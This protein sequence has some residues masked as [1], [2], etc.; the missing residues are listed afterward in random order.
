M[1]SLAG[2]TVTSHGDW[3]A[4]VDSGLEAEIVIWRDEQMDRGRRLSYMGILPTMTH[5]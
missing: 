2:P 3:C 4:F 1:F 5:D